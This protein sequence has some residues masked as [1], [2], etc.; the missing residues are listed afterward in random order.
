MK[1]EIDIWKRLQ[2]QI[3]D[4][5][6]EIIVGYHDRFEPTEVEKTMKEFMEELQEEVPFHRIRYFRYQ[7]TVF[8]DRTNRIDLITGT[9]LL[10]RWFY[11]D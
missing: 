5:L 9:N 2:Q 11:F 10:Q 4:H 6:D 3:P 7:D 1:R 8:W